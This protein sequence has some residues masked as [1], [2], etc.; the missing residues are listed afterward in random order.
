ML[1]ILLTIPFISH[2]LFVFTR[3]LN[4]LLFEDYVAFSLWTYNGL[5]IVICISALV[6][7]ISVSL[8]FYFIYLKIKRRKIK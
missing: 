1:K 5:I 4:T 7:V 2:S 3:T 6:F 8:F